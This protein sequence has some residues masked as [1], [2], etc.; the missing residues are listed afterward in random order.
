MQ[1]LDQS[2]QIGLVAVC[3]SD[4]SLWSHGP[5]GNG[6]ANVAELNAIRPDF[7]VQWFHQ[8]GYARSNNPQFRREYDD[9]L[10]GLR[11][12]GVREQ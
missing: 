2:E 12:A 4:F 6:A 11:K 10:D 8:M 1:A 3:G 7:T 5:I 9:I